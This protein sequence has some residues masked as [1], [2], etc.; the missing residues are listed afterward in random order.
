MLDSIVNFGTRLSHQHYVTQL[1]LHCETGY[2]DSPIP[3]IVHIKRTRMTIINFYDLNRLWQTPHLF[4][5]Q[6]EEVRVLR[7]QPR[8]S[9]KMGLDKMMAF[10]R[11]LLPFS[12]LSLSSVDLGVVSEAMKVLHNYDVD[13]IEPIIPE[14]FFDGYLAGA[15]TWEEDT[16]ADIQKYIP[17]VRLMSSLEIDR[18]VFSMWPTEASEWVVRP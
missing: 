7:A 9:Q 13:D 8:R 12:S 14:E 11:S 6:L 15:T 5:G 2:A 4:P 18:I 3:T 1:D 10:F 17:R 16:V